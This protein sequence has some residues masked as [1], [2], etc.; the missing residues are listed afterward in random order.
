M[1]IM[2]SVIDI[3]ESAMFESAMIESAID[4]IEPAIV[5]GYLA[6]RLTYVVEDSHP[7]HIRLSSTLLSSYRFGLSLITCSSLHFSNQS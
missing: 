3:I 6:Q 7:N 1:D 4:M 5:S 2:G